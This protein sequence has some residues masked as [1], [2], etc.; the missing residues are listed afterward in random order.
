VGIPH[1]LT[2]GEVSGESLLAEEEL[3]TFVIFH[4]AG[5]SHAGLEEVFL[6]LTLAAAT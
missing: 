5:V 6:K 4:Q 1:E 3:V 2:L